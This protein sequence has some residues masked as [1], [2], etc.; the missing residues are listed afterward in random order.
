[1]RR[2]RTLPAGVIEEV[3]VKS[4]LIPLGHWF[5]DPLRPLVRDVCGFDAI[6]R[7]GSFAGT[8][9]RLMLEHESQRRHHRR[10][11]STLL[12]FQLGAPAPAS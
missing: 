3:T 10:K 6:R 2:C 7:G 5:R 1:M 4:L 11:L 8:V 12:A 9:E